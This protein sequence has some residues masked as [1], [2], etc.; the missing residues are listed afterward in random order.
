M[1]HPS[2][3]QSAENLTVGFRRVRKKIGLPF[4]LTFSL[5]DGEKRL[6][7]CGGALTDKFFYENLFPFHFLK[8]VRDVFFCF[9]MLGNENF[10]QGVDAPLYFFQFP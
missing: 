3:Y 1:G 6:L 9:F 2:I 5:H 7:S 8:P 10:L 4:N